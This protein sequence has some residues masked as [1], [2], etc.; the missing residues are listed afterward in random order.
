[1][2]SFVPLTVGVVLYRNEKEEIRRLLTSIE[3]TRA[4][5]RTPSF[6]VEWYDNSVDP[7]YRASLSTLGITSL[8]FSGENVGFG[9][10]HNVLMRAAFARSETRAYLCLNP[11]A[12]VHPDMFAELWARAE[13]LDN[14]GL[15]EALQF[16]SEHPKPYDPVTGET[17]WCSGCALLLTRPLY[18]RIGG[19]DDRIFLYCEDVD[20]SW[21]ARAAGFQIA[22]APRALVHHYV[23]D[24]LPGGRTRIEMLRAGAYLGRKWGGSEFTRSCEREFFAL[25][26]SKLDL[27]PVKA[28]AASAVADFS[29]SF[30]FSAARW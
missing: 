22:V 8:A 23:G 30:S 2:G 24:R 4:N 12:I 18:E 19:Y 10:A 11:D 29:T 7:A 20:L 27:A 3:Q 5:P 17:A 16:P 25:T 13:Q 28:E 9:R 26:G 14:P 6:R 1:M 15:V 21:R